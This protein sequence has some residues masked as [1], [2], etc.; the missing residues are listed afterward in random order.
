MHTITDIIFMS[1]IV[2][3]P[4]ASL[5]EICE[6][7]NLE[8]SGKTYEL[9]QRIWDNLSQHQDEALEQC[10]QKLLAGQTSVVWYRVE[11]DSLNNLEDVLIQY[12]PFNPFQEI[13]RP[14]FD[15]LPQ[16]PQIMCAA[17][18]INEGEYFVRFI[19]QDG[20][21]RDVGLTEMQISPRSEVTTVYLN[22]LTGTIEV[23]T[24]A[25]KAS[26]VISTLGLLLRQ[27][28]NLEQIEAP[29]GQ[30]I[31]TTA[32]NLNGEL[33]DATSK[34][35][36]ILEDFTTQHAETVVNILASL[37]KYMKTND[38]NTLEEDLK[39][40]NEVFDDDMV[41]VPFAALIL[42]GLD[43]VGLGGIGELRGV[44][45][46]ESLSPYLQHQGAYIR[47]SDEGDDEKQYTIRIGLTTKSI[48]F[49]TPSTEN[50]IKYV[51]DRLI[52]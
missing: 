39:I 36:L 6:S 27:Q 10:K 19:Y 31:E 48:Y 16:D 15:E 50:V 24:D 29:F 21:R 22:V 43:K 8:I 18:G 17:R 37:D 25:K 11:E 9:S 52:V 44:P 4:K 40:I 32:V 14:N 41:S 28:V 3:L 13:R 33:I 38:I 45:L 46:F 7:M 23:R 12:C 34:P 51:R 42:N 26:K 1:D 47:F 5:V 35:E 30:S 2:R 20:V 49:N